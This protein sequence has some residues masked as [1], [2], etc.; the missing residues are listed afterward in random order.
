MSVIGASKIH[1]SYIWGYPLGYEPTQSLGFV[2][3]LWPELTGGGG[4]IL[5]FVGRDLL[6]VTRRCQ[7]F[8]LN[9]YFEEFQ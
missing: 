3:V 9:M 2:V 1:E 8:H 7:P 6:L 5:A 4:E